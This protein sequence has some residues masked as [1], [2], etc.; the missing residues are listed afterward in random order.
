M[1]GHFHYT[2]LGEESI[3]QGFRTRH[4][5]LASTDYSW[6]H[7]PPYPVSMT[8]AGNNDFNYPSGA[9]GYQ[10]RPRKIT[11]LLGMPCDFSND[12]PQEIL[13]RRHYHLTVRPHWM[14]KKVQV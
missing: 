6:R 8:M 10:E 9:S 7:R 3:G 14:R 12:E 4:A 5:W 13:G 2:K 1:P 11:L